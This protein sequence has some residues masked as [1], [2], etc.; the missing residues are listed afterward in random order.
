M[1]EDEDEAVLPGLPSSVML[2][3][4]NSDCTGSNEEFWVSV[5]YEIDWHYD[6]ENDVVEPT[7]TSGYAETAFCGSCGVVAWMRDIADAMGDDMEVELLSYE[8][9]NDD[10]YECPNDECKGDDTDFLVGTK[11]FIRREQDIRDKTSEAETV[12]SIP[13]YAKCMVCGEMNQLADNAIKKLFGEE[14]N[15]SGEPEHPELSG[16]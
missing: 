13:V 9:D 2:T 16:D 4:D 7:I 5:V 8:P 6:P 10:L 14:S 15:E 3:C 12:A 11:H 1:P